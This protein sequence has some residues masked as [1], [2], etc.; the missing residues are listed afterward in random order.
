M[1]VIKMKY[2]VLLLVSTV[3]ISQI[4]DASK[5]A[6][7]FNVDLNNYNKIAKDSIKEIYNKQRQF[8]SK[9]NENVELAIS[10]NYKWEDLSFYSIPIYRILREASKKYSC[11]DNIEKYIVFEERNKYQKVLLFYKNKILRDIDVPDFN[12]EMDRIYNPDYIFQSF[13]REDKNYYINRLLQ[14]KYEPLITEYIKPLEEKDDFF[15]MIFGLKDVLFQIDNKNRILYARSVATYSETIYLDGTQSNRDSYSKIDAND[16]IRKYI[17]E[18]K[19][20]DIA[21]GIFLDFEENNINS[22]IP[23]SE[24]SIQSSTILLNV[25]KNAQ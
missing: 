14:Y 11:A 9:N 13:Y 3:S 19:I 24:N 18:N 23:C 17:G 10:Q 2:L 16:F 1:E 7:N 4:N 21:N 6:I 8:Y 25:T 12:Y 5:A 22:Q 20:R 15:F